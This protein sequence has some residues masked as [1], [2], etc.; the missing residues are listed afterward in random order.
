[1]PLQSGTIP[2]PV[3][4]LF[5]ANLNSLKDRRDKLSRTFHQ[6]MCKPASCLH[7][8]LPPLATLLLRFLGYVLAHHFLVQP[9]EQKSLDHL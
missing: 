8:L 5:V 7:Y 2:S 9:H 1:M 4:I 6:N 3:L